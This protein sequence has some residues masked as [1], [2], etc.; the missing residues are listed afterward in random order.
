M[1][2]Q[3]RDGGGEREN[4]EIVLNESSRQFQ[5]LEGVIVDCRGKGSGSGPF[6]GLARSRV[7]VF[8]GRSLLLVWNVKSVACRHRTKTF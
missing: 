7:W 8:G 3:G 2:G 4:R 6:R 5:C 1:E